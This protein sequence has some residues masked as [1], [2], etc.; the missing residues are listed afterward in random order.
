MQNE[1]VIAYGS[2]KLKTYEQN[3]HTHDLELTA[4][5]FALKRWRQYLYGAKFEVFTD[6]K[7]FKVFVLTKGV[8]YEAKKMD[9][10]VER[11]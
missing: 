10:I 9:G 6:H 7:K 4:V 8:K 11:L 5:V 1:K 3:Y 2:R